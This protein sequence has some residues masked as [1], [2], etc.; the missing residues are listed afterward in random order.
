MIRRRA[1]MDT[2]AANGRKTTPATDTIPTTMPV[3]NNVPDARLNATSTTTNRANYIN[4]KF[5]RRP[6]SSGR[7]SGRTTAGSRARRRPN[8]CTESASCS[9]RRRTR[10]I[11][12]AEGE[13]DKNTSTALNLL[14]VTNPGGAGKWNSDFTPEQIERWFKGRQTAYVLEDNDAPG[15]KHVEIVGHALHPLVADIRIVSFRELP[16]KGDV[17]DWIE[18][19]H[20]KAEL[21]ARAA[22]SPKYQPPALQSV[23]A[24]DV[25]MTAVEW[26]WP[27]RFASR[28]ARH[29]RRPAGRG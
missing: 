13:K 29:H 19:G 18:L 17:T 20:T 25:T 9:R 7:K 6:R 12:I 10:Q 8:I 24:A 22:A 2:I 23:Y 26:L 21:L 11:W 3:A 1:A 15:R 16:E 5:D 27:N 14:A 4:E 28:Q